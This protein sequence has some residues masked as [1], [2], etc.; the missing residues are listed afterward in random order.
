MWLRLSKCETPS[1]PEHTS[2]FGYNFFRAGLCVSL[3][4]EAAASSLLC[5]EVNETRRV[6]G[7]T[8]RG[9]TSTLAVSNMHPQ[10]IGEYSYYIYQPT[11]NSLVLGP[12]DSVQLITKFATG[13]HN[14]PVSPI[15]LQRAESF[16]KSEQFLRQTRNSPH[17]TQPTDSLPRLQNITTCPYPKQYQSRSRSLAIL[18]LGSILILS[19]HLSLCFQSYNI[20]INIIPQNDTVDWTGLLPISE[21][22]G[23]NTDPETNYLEI[24]VVFLRPLIRSQPLLSTSFKIH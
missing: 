10:K 2:E 16:L 3:A 23:S 6:V 20:G 9:A 17:F 1:Q 5:G 11:D 19:S 24:I 7:E 15:R 4:G 14:E 18:F 8:R 13:R 22:W 12:E 21:I